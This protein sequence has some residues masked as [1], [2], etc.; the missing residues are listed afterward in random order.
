MASSLKQ[1][2][3]VSAASHTI[4]FSPELCIICQEDD[5]EREPTTAKNGRERVIEAALLRKDIVFER[6]KQVENRNFVYHVT[7]N[8]KY[9][10]QFTHKR[11]VECP[12]EKI[13]ES[14]W[15]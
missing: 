4:S 6:L 10:K 2:F 11:T 7:D 12:K 13:R 5:P 15:Y 9:Y 14:Q 8:F 1:R 3:R